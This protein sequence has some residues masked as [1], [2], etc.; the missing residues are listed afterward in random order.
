MPLLTFDNFITCFRKQFIFQTGKGGRRISRYYTAK[1]SEQRLKNDQWAMMVFIHLG[2]L[3]GFS[4]TQI[5]EELNIR[6]SLYDTLKEEVV[7]VLSS[8]Y[9]DKNLHKKVVCKA[10]LV[11]N[12]VF[13]TYGIDVSC[14]T[15]KLSFS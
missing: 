11:R 3:Y 13:Y 5:I 14:S 8:N 6:K 12:L 1:N 15:P 7:N 4:D 10:G 9:P 2:H